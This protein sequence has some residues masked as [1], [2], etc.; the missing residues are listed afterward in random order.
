MWKR[1]QV[2]SS[3]ISQRDSVIHLT[4]YFGYAFSTPCLQSGLQSAGCVDQIPLETGGNN[5][6]MIF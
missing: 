6:K 1:V 4:P 2:L 3:R 5:W